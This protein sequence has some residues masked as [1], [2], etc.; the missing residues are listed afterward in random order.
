[1]IKISSQTERL[2]ASLIISVILTLFS[3]GCQAFNQSPVIYSLTASAE[4]VDLSAST[5]IKCD[6]RDPDRD[7][8]TY[9][10]SASGGTISGEGSTVTWV[11]PEK[12]GVYT[13]TVTLSDGRGG[14]ATKEVTVDVLAKGNS[15]PLIKSLTSIPKQ[16]DIYDD[17]TVTL[18]CVAVDLDGDD[19][20]SYTWEVTG[21]TIKGE[22]PTVVWTPPIVKEDYEEHNVSVRATDSKGNRSVRK[23]I[24]FNV[25]CDCL[26][27]TSEKP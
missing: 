4:Q 23:F 27:P 22:G 6:A 24:T 14:E 21:G 15:P 13:I 16:R 2:V 10:W 12:S 17:E 3:I 26:R 18:T 5:Q 25:A 8:I 19:I 7:E 1:M 11:A 20:V 9:A